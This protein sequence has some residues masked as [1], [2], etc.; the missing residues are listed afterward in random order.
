MTLVKHGASIGGGA[1]ILPGVTI[2]ERAM[3][4]AG[5]VVTK[6]VPDHAVV[7]GNPAYIV[8]FVE[9]ADEQASLSEDPKS[10]K[11]SG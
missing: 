1:V 3:I 11:D 7:V 10:G 8:R 9:V 6:S 5:A 2:G 4:G